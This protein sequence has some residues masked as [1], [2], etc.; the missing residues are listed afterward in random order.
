MP[1]I[2]I[3]GTIIFLIALAIY[4]FIIIKRKSANWGKNFWFISKGPVVAVFLL[5]VY[6]M[7]TFVFPFLSWIYLKG[8]YSIPN[9]PQYD[10][11]DTQNAS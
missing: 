8:R 6:K 5:W 10:P 11:N 1:K 2:R 9:V 7:I 3:L 4:F